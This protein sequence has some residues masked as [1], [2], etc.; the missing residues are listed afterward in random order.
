[1]GKPV[2]RRP[3]ASYSSAGASCCPPLSCSIACPQKDLSPGWRIMIIC[4]LPLR[5]A[6]SFC[7]W[8]VYFLLVAFCLLGDDARLL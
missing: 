4:D 1:M 7:M 5:E 6:L 3:K 2:Q 8:N